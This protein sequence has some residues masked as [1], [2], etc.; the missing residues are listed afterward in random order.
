M[1]DMKLMLR[2]LGNNAGLVSTLNN[3]RGRVRSFSNS[4]KSEFNGMQKALNSVQNRLAGIG[5]TIG[6]I[7][8][9]RLSANLDKGLTRMAQT[10]GVAVKNTQ[11]LRR[12]YFA[13]AKETGAKV[14]V[15][16]EGFDSLV[17][18]GL[19]LKE[20]KETIKG[21]N[22]AMAVTGAQAQTLAAGLT[23]AAT[24]YSFDLS[25]QGKALELLDKMTAAGRLGNAELENLSD[26]FGRVG[27]NAASA[28]M[29][30]ENT[31]AFIEALSLVERSPERL[32]TLADS[33]LRVFTNANYMKAAQKA[34]GV[35]FFDASG[36]RRA[37]LDVFADI[38][39]Q[40][41]KLKT[42][43][44]RS[45]FIQK[46]FGKADLD[47]I[48]GVRTLLQGSSLDKMAQFNRNIAAAGGTLKRDMGDALSNAVDQTGRLKATLREA[49]DAFIQPINEGISKAIKFGLNEKSKGGLG[50]S[51]KQIILGGLG[52]GAAA[53]LT[54]RMGKGL[55][56]KLLSSGGSLATGV[57][58]G[59]AVEYAAG[60]TPVFVVNW[61]GNGAIPVPGI[62]MPGG[63]D[64][65]VG[66]ATDAAMKGMLLRGAGFLL[67]RAGLAGT[68]GAAGYG[69]GTLLNKGAGMLAGSIT[70]GRYADE[71]WLGQLLYDLA[72][73]DAKNE[74]NITTHIDEK[75]RTTTTADGVNARVNARSNRGSLLGK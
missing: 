21:I 34:T 27:V 28:G 24:A 46:A 38:K 10:A 18:S 65:S 25:K 49:A 60:V 66:K 61:P 15:L 74:I 57:A 19:S 36:S 30:F 9:M 23:V 71:G 5:L 47:T 73:K 32:A 69:A 6:A 20:A 2:L 48:K 75:G 12:E 44:A 55:A 72:H 64:K 45:A 3:S 14:E 43:K 59:K 11:A 50:L 68:A 8:Q 29:G 58:A 42:D 26:I 35:R 56:S 54:A 39:K 51:G 52:L 4:V 16:T 13:M 17:Q 33:T 7:Q 31:L 70:G 63:I 22:V 41:D 53:L 62:R 1:T 67:G 40:Y 37:A